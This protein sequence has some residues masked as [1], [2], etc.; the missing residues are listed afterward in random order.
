M[1]KLDIQKRN[2]LIRFVFNL[3]SRELSVILSLLRRL[4]NKLDTIYFS[5]LIHWFLYS[6]FQDNKEEKNKIY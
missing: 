5:F 2:M 3:R 4:Q 1:N 6:N